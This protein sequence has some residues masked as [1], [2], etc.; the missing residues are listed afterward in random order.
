MF[1]I[2][3]KLVLEFWVQSQNLD[4][5]GYIETFEITVSQGPYVTTGFDNHVR[6]ARGRG[7][8]F[9]DVATHQITFACGQKATV[10]EVA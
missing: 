6:I 2:L 9:A 4:E 10:Y 5:A 8:M 1:N 7:Q 3:G